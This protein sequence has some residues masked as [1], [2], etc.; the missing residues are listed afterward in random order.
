MRN[1]DEVHELAEIE[2]GVSAEARRCTKRW[3]YC[4]P[5]GYAAHS[6]SNRIKNAPFTPSIPWNSPCFLVNGAIRPESVERKGKRDVVRNLGQSALL[7]LHDNISDIAAAGD[8]RFIERRCLS[9]FP[10]ENDIAAFNCAP[11][12]QQRQRPGFMITR[13]GLDRDHALHRLDAVGEGT[14]V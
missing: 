3:N 14:V 2:D 5:N 11:I 1:L 12:S 6:D 9:S 4:N 10:L 7:L 8:G 13:P